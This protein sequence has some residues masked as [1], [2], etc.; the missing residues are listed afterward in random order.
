MFRS[1]LQLSVSL[2][3]RLS[4][5]VGLLRD[6]VKAILAEPDSHKQTGLRDLT[7]MILLY[8]TAARL[9]GHSSVETTMVYLDITAEQEIFLVVI[10]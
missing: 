1:I 6:A 2:I 3:A 9:L 4:K 5:V 10:I 7:L 8:G